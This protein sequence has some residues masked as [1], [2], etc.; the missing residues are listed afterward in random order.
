MPV[1]Y[2]ARDLPT[3]CAPAGRPSCEMEQ[4]EPTSAKPTWFPISLAELDAMFM[5][6]K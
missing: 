6:G 3:P 1:G 4:T 2:C 5:R